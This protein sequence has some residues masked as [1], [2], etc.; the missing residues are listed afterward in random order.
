MREVYVCVRA[1]ARAC[2]SVQEGEPVVVRERERSL[3]ARHLLATRLLCHRH[4]RMAPLDL[5]EARGC[6]AASNDQAVAAG[7]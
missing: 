3:R 6:Q 5:A 7:H 4:G 2:T 1:R